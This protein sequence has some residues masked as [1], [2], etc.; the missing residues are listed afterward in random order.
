MRRCRVSCEKSDDVS[1]HALALDSVDGTQKGLH[2]VEIL[3]QKATSN[4]KNKKLLGKKVVR[5]K[6][7][8]VIETNK[9][10]LKT[11]TCN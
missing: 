9:K 6:K 7:L 2:C 5:N 8:F 1:H 4:R 11:A 3:E 10:L